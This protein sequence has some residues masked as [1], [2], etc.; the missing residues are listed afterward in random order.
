MSV[1]R[2]GTPARALAAGLPP[3]ARTCRPNVVRAT[4]DG[5]ER[6]RTPRAISTTIGMPKTRDRTRGAE[7]RVEDLGQ[8]ALGDDEGDAPA[9]DEQRQR[10]DDGLDPDARD[11]DRR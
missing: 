4:S 3:M 11:Q 2:T 6:A 7:R 8:P 9:G 10:R 5:D 1:R